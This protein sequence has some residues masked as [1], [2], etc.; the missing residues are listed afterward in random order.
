M[1]QVEDAQQIV[2]LMT[3]KLVVHPVRAMY[4]FDCVMA[5]S[6]QQDKSILEILKIGHERLGDLIQEMED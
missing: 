1:M 2:H 3:K 6:I 4:I 5:L